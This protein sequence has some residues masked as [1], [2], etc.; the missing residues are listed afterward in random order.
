MNIDRL[1]DRSFHDLSHSEN[2][3]TEYVLPNLALK[4]CTKYFHNIRIVMLYDFSFDPGL[5]VVT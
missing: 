4:C 1:K 3:E 5:T 2:M